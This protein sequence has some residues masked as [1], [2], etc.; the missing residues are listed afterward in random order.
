MN[1]LG[2]MKCEICYEGDIKK[3][4]LIDDVAILKCLSCGYEFI[5]PSPSSEEL[6]AGYNAN[7]LSSVHYY[8]E[9]LD[10]E[11]IMFLNRYKKIER[12]IPKSGVLLDVG[13]NIGTCSDIF[14]K[15]G[16]E[17]YALDVNKSAIDHIANNSF[18]SFHSFFENFETNVKFDLI[19]MN[20]VIEH[21]H[22]LLPPMKKANELLKEGGFLFLS[23]PLTDSFISRLSGSFWLHYKPDEHLRYFN[24]KNLKLLLS[25]FGLEVVKTFKVTRYRNLYVIFDKLGT[26]ST[27]PIKFI[28]KLHLGPFLKRINLRLKLGDEL[29]VLAVKK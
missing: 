17:I 21:F 16:W 20:D 9:N 13:C 27:L 6:S 11:R 14:N 7:E 10:S 1:T 25:H 18:K 28:D 26:Y 15:H 5:D 12:F 2:L 29:C 24:K 23:T 4:F 8:L 19:L 3:K 22:K